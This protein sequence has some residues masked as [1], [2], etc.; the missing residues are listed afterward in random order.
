M[1]FY[2]EI[3]HHASLLTQGLQPLSH[4]SQHLFFFVNIWILVGIVLCMGLP[5]SWKSYTFSLPIW[6]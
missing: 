5:F 1:R 3:T 2:C 6:K 4:S